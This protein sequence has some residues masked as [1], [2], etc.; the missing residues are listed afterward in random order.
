MYGQKLY[1][2]RVLSTASVA[3]H[4]VDVDGYQFLTFDMQ[5]S[6]WH[7]CEPIF[8]SSLCVNQ[9]LKA[10]SESNSGCDCS[11]PSRVRQGRVPCPELL[12]ENKKRTRDA[13]Q[14]PAGY[15]E[16]WAP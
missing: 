12:A 14:I 16:T 4:T 10:A 6:N 15:F 11:L 13:V 5:T 7:R 8:E 9:C 2:R 3:T 1:M